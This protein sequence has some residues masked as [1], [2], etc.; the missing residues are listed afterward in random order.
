MKVQKK[1]GGSGGVLHVQFIYSAWTDWFKNLLYAGAILETRNVA[2]ARQVLVLRELTLWWEEI[3]NKA[4][5]KLRWIISDMTEN[6]Q[7]GN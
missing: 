5:K 2:W 1:K 3:D 4:N 7:L 6:G